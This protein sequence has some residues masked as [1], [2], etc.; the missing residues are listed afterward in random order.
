MGKA[1]RAVA[2]VLLT[3]PTILRLPATF[4]AAR[5]VY[6]AWLL[7]GLVLT[8]AYQVTVTLGTLVRQRLR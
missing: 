1:S 7:T 2:A 8:A 4:T 5:L 6:G 3:Q